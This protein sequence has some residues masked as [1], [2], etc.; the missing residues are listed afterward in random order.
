MHKLAYRHVKPSRCAYGFGISAGVALRYSF[1]ALFND[2]P[3]PYVLA[4]HDISAAGALS[5][6]V[7]PFVVAQGAPGSLSVKGQPGVSNRQSMAGAIYTGTAAAVPTASFYLQDSGAR[8]AWYHEFPIIVL[9]PGWSL[10]R[11]C[12]T[13]NALS[14][15]SFWWQVL[16]PDELDQMYGLEVELEVS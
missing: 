3:A 5:T 1:A 9:A 13:V 7:T 14:G 8:V 12:A 2:S 4:V 16:T 11:Y 10:A 6:A 15:A